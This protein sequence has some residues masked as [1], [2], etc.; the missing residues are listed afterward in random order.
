MSVLQTDGNFS[1][2]K[3]LPT[4]KNVLTDENYQNDYVCGIYIWT[5]NMLAWTVIT[6]FAFF[7]SVQLQFSYNGWGS[8]IIILFVNMFQTKLYEL[9]EGVSVVDWL[10]IFPF[11]NSVDPETGYALLKVITILKGNACISLNCIW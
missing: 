6:F 8:A 2:G 5:D 4:C 3:K 1:S 11:Y 10:N 9:D 7:P